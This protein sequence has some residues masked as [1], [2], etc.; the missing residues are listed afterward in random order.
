MFRALFDTSELLDYGTPF[1]AALN[2]RKTRPIFRVN[3][4]LALVATIYFRCPT[5]HHQWHD[6]MCEKER[7]KHVHASVGAGRGEVVVL[8]VKAFHLDN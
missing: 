1:I 6:G 4:L 2:H 5:G 7:R 8:A 3:E